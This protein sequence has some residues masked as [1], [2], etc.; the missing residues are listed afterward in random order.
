MVKYNDRAM[1][2]TEYDVKGL[3]RDMF[4]IVAIKHDKIMPE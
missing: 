2:W 3:F 1:S 4:V